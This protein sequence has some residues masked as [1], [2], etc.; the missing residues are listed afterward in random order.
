M[1]EDCLL[2]FMHKL[3]ECNGIKFSTGALREFAVKRFYLRPSFQK[4]DEFSVIIVVQIV[5]IM[6]VCFLYGVLQYRNGKHE[7]N[8]YTLNSV[9]SS[10]SVK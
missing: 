1:Q 3:F 2:R 4:L 10:P 5:S 8:K 9:L 7:R 6:S